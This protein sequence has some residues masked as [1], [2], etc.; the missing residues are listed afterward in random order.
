MTTTESELDN[1]KIRR[2]RNK[3]VAKINELFKVTLTDLYEKNDL[4]ANHKDLLP[5][6][7][8]KIKKVQTDL[9]TDGLNGLFFVAELEGRIVGCVAMSPANR[10]IRKG[11]KGKLTD[12]NEIGSLFVRPSFQGKGI[13][14]RLIDHVIER[15]QSRGVDL[16]CL[17]SGYKTAQSIWT[18]LYGEPAYVMKD[19][20]SEGNDHMIWA[21]TIEEKD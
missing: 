4:G 10:I 21:V 2:L 8:D 20:W 3:D 1:L 17:D 7:N 5:E 15:L 9:D 16:F 12:V 13:G 11:S 14:K 19:Y 6:I 18:H